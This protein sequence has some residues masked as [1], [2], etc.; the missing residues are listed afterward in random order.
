MV[1]TSN[2]YS[3]VKRD[4]MKYFVHAKDVLA[5]LAFFG[6]SS[7]FAQT[8]GSAAG[9]L[10][11]EASDAA[12][13]ALKGDFDLLKI[14][15]LV[16]IAVAVTAGL[17]FYAYRHR[18]LM[19]YDA[20]FGLLLT[21]ALAPL[22]LFV[23]TFVLGAES[24][25]CL[26]AMVASGA[27]A[28][29]FDSVCGTARESAANMIGFTSLWRLIFGEVIVNGLVAPFAAGIVKLLMYTSTVFGSAILYLVIRPFLK[30]I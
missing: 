29:Q 18:R 12:L 17:A 1:R 22:L 14:L 13:V 19:Q 2:R 5:A 23:F 8:I 27:D 9:K 4:E 3:L 28:V 11:T 25:A 6:I 21:V 26:S 16:G 10:A 15:G 20:Q 30:N 7:A 24:H